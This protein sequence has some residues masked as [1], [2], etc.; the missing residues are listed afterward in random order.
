L[1]ATV[2]DL[3]GLSPLLRDIEARFAATA[4]AIAAEDAAVAL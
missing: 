1:L 3:T 4:E 2:A